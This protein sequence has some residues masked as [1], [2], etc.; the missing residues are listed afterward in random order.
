[1]SA[2]Q[3]VPSPCIGV[4]VLDATEVC[5]GCYRHIDEIAGW[6]E[7]SDDE[8]R[9]VLVR[10]DQRCRERFTVRLS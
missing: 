5:E 8:R 6:G 2:G 1:M 4:C 10:A 9:E 7:Y 3:A